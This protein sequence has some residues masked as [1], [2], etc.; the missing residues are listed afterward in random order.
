MAEMQRERGLPT[1]APFADPE[2]LKE[3]S[4]RKVNAILTLRFLLQST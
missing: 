2:M 1:G 4:Y 3:I